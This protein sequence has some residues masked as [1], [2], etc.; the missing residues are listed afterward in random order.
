MGL[1]FIIKNYFKFFDNRDYYEKSIIDISKYDNVNI[2][3]IDNGFINNKILLD[4]GKDINIYDNSNINILNFL[5]IV[6]FF[7]VIILRIIF[8][9]S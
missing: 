5:I 7:V 9:F 6:M 3:D 8:N 1:L 4:M 2:S